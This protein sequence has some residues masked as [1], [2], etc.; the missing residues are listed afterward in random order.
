[1]QFRETQPIYLQ[2]ADYVCE[3]ILL[4]QWA[5]GERIPSVRELAVTLEVNPNTVMRTYEFLQGREIIVNQR[6]VGLFVSDTA[7]Q[8]ALNYRKDEFIEKELPFVFRNLVLLQTS[9]SELEPLFHKYKKRHFPM[10]KE[11]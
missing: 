11:N 8:S 6:G 1:M 10:I 5:A 3:K 9:P 7:H 2:I 4:R